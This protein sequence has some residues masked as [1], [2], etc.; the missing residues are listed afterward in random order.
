MEVQEGKQTGELHLLEL[1]PISN[2]EGDPWIDI[3]SHGMQY[4]KTKA[5]NFNYNG[6]EPTFKIINFR[7]E[8]KHND[9]RQKFREN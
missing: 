5:T 1:S 9:Y 3:S 8:K 6:V 7:R 4:I 2:K